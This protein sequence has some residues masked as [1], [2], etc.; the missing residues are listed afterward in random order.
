M[1]Q[2][3]GLSLVRDTEIETY[4]RA[5]GTPVF[6]AAGLNPDAVNMILVQ[7]GD[8]NA[9]VAGGSNIFFYTGLIEK[10]ETVGELIGVLAHET[11]H[12]AGGHLISTRQAMER[13]SYES[14]VGTILGVG[15]AIASGNSGA[16]VAVSAGGSSVAQRRFL[17]HSRVHESAADQAAL[18]FLE[19]ANIDTSGMVS[20]MT[21]LQ[22]DQYVPRDRQSEYVQT[23]PLVGNRIEALKR[24]TESATTYNKGYPASWVAEHKRMKAKL[25]GFTNPSHVAWTYDDGDTSIPADYA[26]AIAAYRQ[27]REGEAVQRI[28]ALLKREPRN[29]YFLE[30]KGQMLVDFGHSA[31]AITYYE[32][33]LSIMPD[34]PLMRI[35]LAHALI[36]SAGQSG[37]PSLQKSVKHLERALQ[38]EPRSSRAYRL[39]A[40]AY[41]R[42]G[43]ES[44]AKLNLAEEAVLQRR[45]SYAIEHAQYVIE[46][47]AADSA[48]TL[49]AKDLIAFVKTVEKK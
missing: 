26:R 38:D 30:L 15:A 32:R 31:D 33:A 39:L 4:L 27:Y 49:K 6:K 23:H 9:F 10:T 35:A 2:G 8:V 25:V 42:L 48:A 14:I 7:S 37:A 47:S 5:W 1:A 18:T 29:P 3:R 41:G 34:A 44:L 45:F 21:K 28:D 11:G 12:I 13:A 24:R 19:A 46:N 43:Q 36:E 22:A 16:A 17:A 20:F 40:T